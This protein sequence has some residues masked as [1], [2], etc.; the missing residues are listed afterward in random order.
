MLFQQDRFLRCSCEPL[1]SKVPLEMDRQKLLFQLPFSFLL[2][3][4]IEFLLL[5]DITDAPYI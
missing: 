1:I 5:G 4:T 2:P 3:F